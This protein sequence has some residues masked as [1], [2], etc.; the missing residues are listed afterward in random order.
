[1]SPKRLDI[2]LFYT[3]DIVA[4]EISEAVDALESS[5]AFSAE[6]QG[7]LELPSNCYN[8]KRKQY[9]SDC[10][11]SFLKSVKDESA[12]GLWIVG[13]DI[14]TDSYNFV[15]G[16]AELNGEVAVVSS[17]R[18]KSASLRREIYLKRLRTEVVHEAF[19]LAGFQHCSNPYCVM[20]F[21]NTVKDTD[22]KGENLCLV[23]QEKLRLRN[24]F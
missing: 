16:Q 14:Y 8:I 18:L 17:A 23:C 24:T 9:L 5:G 21:S 19:H 2:Q 10:L 11:L 1:M 4:E 13:A 3:P 20:Y 15:F 12:K 7:S 6:L 22:R